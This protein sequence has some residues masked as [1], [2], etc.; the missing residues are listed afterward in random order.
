MKWNGYVIYNKL[1]QQTINWIFKQVCVG[2]ATEKKIQ[3]IRKVNDTHAK[4][5]CTHRRKIDENAINPLSAVQTNIDYIRFAHAGN[6]TGQCRETCD[7]KKL[8]KSENHE[9]E[10]GV[11]ETESISGVLYRQTGYFTRSR[12]QIYRSFLSKVSILWAICNTLVRKMLATSNSRALWIIFDKILFA[13]CV[14]WHIFG[15]HT[16]SALFFAY[17]FEISMMSIF[18]HSPRLI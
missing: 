6:L 16:S 1:Q 13:F 14:A 10:C 18:F 12:Q 5:K 8:D 3:N 17:S 11:N 7:H 9:I 2:R 4:K 15:T